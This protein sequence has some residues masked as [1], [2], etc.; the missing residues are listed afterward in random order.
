[1]D[2]SKARVTSFARFFAF[3]FHLQSTRNLITSAAK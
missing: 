3:R 2:L 1:M